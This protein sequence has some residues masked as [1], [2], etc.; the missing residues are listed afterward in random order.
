MNTRVSWIDPAKLGD[1]LARLMPAAEAT[2]EVRETAAVPEII[3]ADFL[4]APEPAPVV[5]EPIPEPEPV[6]APEV[7]APEPAPP[8]PAVIYA[9]APEVQPVFEPA[10]PAAAVA[11]V[12]NPPP[13]APA[14]APVEEVFNPPPAAPAAAPV[15]E[16][17]LPLDRIR[18]R[19]RVIR[20][21]AVEAGILSHEL[22]PESAPPEPK[23]AFE[24]RIEAFARQATAL[25]ATETRLFVMDADG[26]VLWSN[27]PQPGLVLSTLMAIRSAQH[28][29]LSTL[30]AEEVLTHHDLPPDQVLSVLRVPA[31]SRGPLQIAVKGALPLPKEAAASWSAILSTY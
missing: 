5:R 12:F 26:G 10:P 17:A 20:H 29:S 1:V 3:P 6:R 22:P 23:P 14:A 18:E 15:E 24:Q 25:L 19:L 11:E 4:S 13:A 16:D 31:T 7:I 30:A 28:A 9:A 21:R 27:D 2:P 8:P